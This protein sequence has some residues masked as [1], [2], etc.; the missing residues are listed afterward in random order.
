M[1]VNTAVYD[2]ILTNVFIR[3]VTEDE[4]ALA[5]MSLDV[6]VTSDQTC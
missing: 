4:K 5:R 1:A 3:T 2:Y 6:E